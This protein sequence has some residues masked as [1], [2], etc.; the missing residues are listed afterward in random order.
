MSTVES[1]SYGCVVSILC[2]AT[3]V[4]KARW[5][6][7]FLRMLNMSCLGIALSRTAER[8]RTDTDRQS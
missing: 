8:A 2:S 3:L 1:M 5:S 7:K 6:G 4:R